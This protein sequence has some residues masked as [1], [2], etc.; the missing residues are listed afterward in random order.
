MIGYHHEGFAD[1]KPTMFLPP[2]PLAGH[3]NSQI[4]GFGV[5]RCGSGPGIP[6]ESGP[7]GPERGPPRPEKS[8]FSLVGVENFIPGPAARVGDHFGHPSGVQGNRGK[9]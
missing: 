4:L 8:S 7:R 6:S 5:C 9:F 2:N 3:W 1:L